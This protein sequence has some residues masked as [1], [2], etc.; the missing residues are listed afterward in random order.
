[1]KWGK[2]NLDNVFEQVISSYFLFYFILFAS[3]A[4]ASPR[5]GRFILR[6]GKYAQIISSLKYSRFS[7]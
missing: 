1:M 4:W 5:L 6:L 7:E 2:L 3:K